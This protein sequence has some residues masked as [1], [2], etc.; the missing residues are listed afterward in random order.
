MSQS[1]CRRNERLYDTISANQIADG[2][3]LSRK[4]MT[5]KINMTSYDRGIV[6][7]GSGPMI[8]LNLIE[9]DASQRGSRLHLA[10]TKKETHTLSSNA[11]SIPY[12]RYRRDSDSV[13]SID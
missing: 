10:L 9:T 13:D 1:D 3:T 2:G 7:S 8:S 11:L 12:H 6:L 4:V 5:S